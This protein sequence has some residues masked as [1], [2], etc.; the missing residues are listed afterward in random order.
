MADNLAVI[1]SE[2]L[3]GGGSVLPCG[4]G[5]VIGILTVPLIASTWLDLACVL[6]CYVGGY[7]GGWG[8]ARKGLDLFPCRRHYFPNVVF[9]RWA[10]GTISFWGSLGVTDLE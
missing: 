10:R 7:I 2:M 3:I 6:V 1:S 4:V 5:A 8:P 9:V